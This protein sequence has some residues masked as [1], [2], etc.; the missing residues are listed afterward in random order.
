MV[1][2]QFA[3]PRRRDRGSD[4][5]FPLHSV[6]PSWPGLDRYD[7]RRLDRDGAA[8][9][10]GE[11]VEARDGSLSLLKRIVSAAASGSRPSRAGVCVLDVKFAEAVDRNFIALCRR[12]RDRPLVDRGMIAAGRADLCPPGFHFVWGREAENRP[13]ALTPC[14]RSGVRSENFQSG[15]QSALASR[16]AFAST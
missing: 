12:I 1:A 5:M 10:A 14:R 3:A 4:A 11:R 15:R 13:R 16:P 9:A 7:R 6:P 8:D 2:L